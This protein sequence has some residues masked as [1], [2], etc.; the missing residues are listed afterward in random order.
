MGY[1]SWNFRGLAYAHRGLRS[2]AAHPSVEALLRE[3][4]ERRQKTRV[5]E[6]LCAGDC[7]EHDGERFVVQVPLDR[8]Y[9]AVTLRVDERPD[10]RECGHAGAPERVVVFGGAGLEDRLHR[11]RIGEFGQA[12]YRARFHDTI[13]GST[14]QR[15]P[16]RVEGARVLRLAQRGERGRADEIR[17]VISRRR[18][19]RRGR[20]AVAETP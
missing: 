3:A 20:I 15:G 9:G 4:V 16:E 17:L 1:L 8:V 18:D 2:V 12:E 13:P 6:R 10:P 5:A 14:L 7:G 19:Q 11:A